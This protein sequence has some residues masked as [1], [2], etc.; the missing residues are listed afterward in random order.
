[1]IPVSFV[2]H[3][4]KWIKCGFLLVVP[5][6]FLF[7]S[8]IIYKDFIWEVYTVL[9]ILLLPQSVIKFTVKEMVS[10]YV[11]VFLYY[12]IVVVKE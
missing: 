6:R 12:I 9:V 8:N 5:H 2:P 7:Y 10:N 1:M 11:R 3:T 4:V